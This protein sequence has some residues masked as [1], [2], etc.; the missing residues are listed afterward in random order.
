MGLTLRR[1][2]LSDCYPVWEWKNAPDVRAVSWTTEEIAYDA[3]RHWFARAL[4]RPDLQLDIVMLDDTPIGS[5]RLD[6]FGPLGLVSIVLV[7]SARGQG[8]G[9][10][11]LRLL[12][13]PDDLLLL[14]ALIRRENPASSQAFLSAGYVLGYA[15]DRILLLVKPHAVHPQP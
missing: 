11:A 12:T 4:R 15:T 14:L 8:H 3:H 13:P 2:E 5:V 7:P 9:S 1:A 10:A 6:R